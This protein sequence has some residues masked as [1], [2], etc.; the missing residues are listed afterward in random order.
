MFKFP[1]C[2][3][4]IFFHG[5]STVSICFIKKIMRHL[6][7]LIFNIMLSMKTRPLQSIELWRINGRGDINKI[8]FR[9]LKDHYD[10]LWPC[11]IFI[12]YF[13]QN[14]KII[15]SACYQPKSLQWGQSA[16]FGS[17]Y[18]NKWGWTWVKI[19]LCP[20]LEDGVLRD[21]KRKYRLFL[22]QSI[23]SHK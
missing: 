8:S 4:K 21:P 17:E 22:N 11:L 6:F 12:F 18:I 9:V 3:L 20:N 23:G 10:R 13:F 7:N 5:F 19:H 16:H 15:F 2:N 14:I 1:K